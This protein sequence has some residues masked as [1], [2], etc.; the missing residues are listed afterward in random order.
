MRCRHILIN[1]LSTALL[2]EVKAMVKLKPEQ[3]PWLE[4]TELQF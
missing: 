4:P 3:L 2:A 1:V